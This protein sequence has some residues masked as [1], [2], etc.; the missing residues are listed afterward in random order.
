MFE[1]FE[2]FGRLVAAVIVLLPSLVAAHPATEWAKA[3]FAEYAAKVFGKVPEARFV[4]PGETSD[5]ADDFKALKGTDGYAVRT[6]GGTLCF[7][8]DN[9]KGFIN[10]VHRW[11]E[12]NSDIIWPRPAKDICFYTPACQRTT[13]A[14]ASRRLSPVDTRREDA[15]GTVSDYIDIPAF[16]LRY[17][18]AE[19]TDPEVCRWKVRNAT[20]GMVDASR[21]SPENRELVRQYGIYGTF[22]DSYGLGHSMERQWFPRSEFFKGHPEY[23]MLAGGQR[24]PGA[25]CNFCETNP[26][27]PE[28]YAK[29]VLEKIRDLPSE[30]KILQIMMEDTSVTCQC[31][32]CQKPIRLADGSLLTADDPA[33]K[34]T[35]FFIFFNKVA[36][37]IGARRP[38][39]RIRQ[40]AYQQ[41]AVPPKV[42]IEPNVTI[43]YCPYPRNMKES[44][45]NGP[46]NVKWRERTDA[47]L[48][49]TRNLYWR[50][51]YFCGCIYFPRP[52]AETVAEDMRY[53]RAKGVSEVY[54][55]SPGRRGDRADVINRTY[56]LN[57][58]YSQY[59]DMNALE[60]WVVGK[61]FWDP[62]AD[63][64]ALRKEYLRRTFGPSAEAVG[65][66]Y[67][68]IHRAWKA[69][70]KPSRY[71]DSPFA[72]AAYYIVGKKLS[73][74]CRAALAEAEAKADHPARKAWIASMRD[75]LDKWIG[76][77]SNY[78]ASD[79][80]IPFSRD[81]GTAA[82][83]PELKLSGSP[84]GLDATRSIF[85]I[86]SDGTALVV[87]ADVKKP[88]VPGEKAEFS[89]APTSG[90]LYTFPLEV[91]EKTRKGWKAAARIPFESAHY[92][93]HVSSKFRCLPRLVLKDS[94]QATGVD[95]TWLGGV[96]RM[97]ET[98]GTA[99][100]NLE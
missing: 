82:E 86:R 58:P 17:V 67:S 75:I 18:G 25:S 42:P 28:A 23:Y 15:S 64:D 51:Y 55:D 39:L 77:A 92:A 3:E 49:L 53:I 85:T 70:P 71:D 36:K 48:N 73:D 44:V 65:R 33:F 47:W 88:F 50:E 93:P 8:A 97:P 43:V 57:R 24:G 7:V 12:K 40:Y 84:A 35:R 74:A 41:L 60:V 79:F 56:G 72:S 61:L 96:A 94:E 63:V 90:G 27:L 99:F 13:L 19:S 83:F 14:T 46:S 91:T 87:T 69:D 4:L 21:L 78:I 80:E 89:I 68:L 31:P 29:S 32:E 66:F 52:I 38:D 59:F 37:L 10:G 30:V 20:S 9:P 22:A 2:K 6:R 34:S 54:C 16:R 11:L 5:F 95:F 26:E 76:E 81:G 45:V 62:E 100:S 1:T 98:W